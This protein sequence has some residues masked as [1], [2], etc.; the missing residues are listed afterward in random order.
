MEVSWSNTYGFCKRIED[1][2][3]RKEA[4][5]AFLRSGENDLEEE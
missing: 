2:R 3:A 4:E 5:S 1:S